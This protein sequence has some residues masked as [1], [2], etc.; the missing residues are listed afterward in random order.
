MDQRRQL[1]DQIMAL[2]SQFGMSP[3]NLLL[4]LNVDALKSKLVDLEITPSRGAKKVDLVRMI[5][6]DLELTNND[7]L[8]N[9][10]SHV[11]GES[12]EM[13]I[14][15]FAEETEGGLFVRA[16]QVREEVVHDGPAHNDDLR[17]RL[18][19]L[20]DSIA[21]LSSLVTGIVDRMRN[22]DE[23]ITPNVN[24]DSPDTSVVVATHQG[25]RPS[26][27]APDRVSRRTEDHKSVGREN[28][29]ENSRENEITVMSELLMQKLVALDRIS[30]KSLL[31]KEAAKKY[32]KK[33]FSN[34][35]SQK[36]YD[37]WSGVMKLFFRYERTHLEEERRLISQEIRKL[38]GTRLA[39][40]DVAETF[41]WE[42][43]D[44]LDAK[45]DGTY[46]ED[47]KDSV[48]D[49]LKIGGGKKREFDMLKF[50]HKKSMK[51]PKLSQRP[52]KEDKGGEEKDTAVKSP[53]PKS[54]PGNVSGSGR[55]CFACGKRDH[56]ARD[57]HAT[58]AEKARWRSRYQYNSNNNSNISS[59]K[60]T[61]SISNQ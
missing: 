37:A 42:A 55:V 26:Q 22:E 28:L 23:R 58:E 4:N 34:H 48:M 25:V 49:A 61:D 38:S 52:F 47:V 33:E 5:A 53:F 6:E 1:R 7:L 41:G 56:Y 11:D 32:P 29:R 15:G 36:E 31:E 57:C 45:R 35:H 39:M 44:L 46:L 27:A 18:G 12:E 16:P 43:A 20:E 19:H 54:S 51:K 10:D 50:D 59:N 3:Y 9:G 14:G 2:A 13:D 24:S 8:T 17:D 60:S 30:G 40:L 21:S